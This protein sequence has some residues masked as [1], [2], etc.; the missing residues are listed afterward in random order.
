[1]ASSLHRAKLIDRYHLHELD[2]RCGLD[3]HEMDWAAS[4]EGSCKPSSICGMLRTSGLPLK[5]PNPVEHKNLARILHNRDGKAFIHSP[6]SSV[7][8]NTL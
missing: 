3:V 1:M 5:L 6:C 8:Y 4:Q 7:M 2:A